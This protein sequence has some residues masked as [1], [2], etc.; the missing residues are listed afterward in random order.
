MFF[1]LEMECV[2]GEVSLAG[3][4]VPM[5]DDR[6]SEA[7]E[8]MNMYLQFDMVLSDVSAFLADGDY[9]WSRTSSN[10]KAASVSASDVS[11]LPVIDKCGVVL[12][13][14]QVKIFSCSCFLVPNVCDLL[15]ISC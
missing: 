9:Y 6:G 7:P 3:D 14:Q 8:T 15:N 10:G 1:C 11:L 13:L 5:Q 12:R 4:N 2:F